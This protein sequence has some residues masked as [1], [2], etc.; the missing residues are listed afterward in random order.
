LT[1][2]Q[3]IIKNTD[4]ILPSNQII[5]KNIPLNVK[6]EDLEKHFKSIQSDILELR[7]IVNESYQTGFIDFQTI[8]KAENCINKY[9]GVNFKGRK[10][11]ISY[12]QS[13]KKEKKEKFKEKEISKEDLLKLLE[14]LET[15]INQEMKNKEFKEEMKIEHEE[16]IENKIDLTIVL[17]NLSYINSINICDCLH[18]EN[19]IPEINIH[20][21]RYFGHYQCSKC[22]RKW[23][24]GYCWKNE[25]QKC[26]TCNSDTSPYEI[27]QLKKEKSYEEK[28]HQSDKCS[29]CKKYG[30]CKTLYVNN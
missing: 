21:C 5:I 8:E 28:E 14:L 26:Q 19:K 22:K 23:K 18:P 13:K 10:L 27:E 20:V 7:I 9:N 3:K 6:K 29:M 17:K 1:S 16:N 4:K 11:K 25:T 15:K 30:L 24:S 12:C 2:N